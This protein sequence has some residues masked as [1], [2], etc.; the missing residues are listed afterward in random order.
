MQPLMQRVLP[1]VLWN[2]TL[3]RFA[4]I[5]GV[6]FIVDSSVFAGALYF[7]LLPL[8]PAR[9]TAFICSASATWLGNRIFTFNQTGGNLFKQWR[10]FLV[11]ACI[12]AVPNFMVFT[13][14]VSWFGQGGYMP[15]IALVC[16]I[17]TGMFSNYFLCTRWVF[18][19]G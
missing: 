4:F 16:G 1:D 14:V 17:L 10:N 7:F 3:F 13:L 5:G 8:F 11:S 9:A 19:K 15:F 12:S 6:G 2:S 18:V